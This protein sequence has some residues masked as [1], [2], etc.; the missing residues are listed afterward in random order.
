MANNRNFIVFDIETSGLD[1][2]LGAEIVQISAVALRYSDYTEIEN[3]RFD[4]IIKPQKP[5]KASK[6]AI[7]VIGKDLWDRANADGLHPKVAL[8]KF[9]EYIEM[10]NPT[11]KFWTSPVLVG[12]N[13]VNFDI[14]FVQHQ[15][16]EY[17]ILDPGDD[18]PWS[19][20]QMDLFPLMFSIFGRDGLK[21][22][23]LDTYANLI[24]LA[25]SA[26]THDASED[27]DITKQMFQRYMKFMNF[28]I[29]PKINAKKEESL[30]Q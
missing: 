8:R 15:M 6:E 5:D 22:N 17:K 16:E 19:N 23:K 29:R 26:E 25:R 18:K 1:P 4:I 30:A 21:N 13:I 27:V 11:K 20:M 14:P 10:I 7:D 2:K 12:F 3:G 24:G 9:K 28:K